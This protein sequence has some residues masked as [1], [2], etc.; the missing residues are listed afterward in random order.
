MSDCWRIAH[1]AS[2][3]NDVK[4]GSVIFAVTIAQVRFGVRFRWP[5]WHSGPFDTSNESVL[6]AITPPTRRSP[7]WVRPNAF[8]NAIFTVLPDSLLLPP[9]PLITI[10]AA[11]ASRTRKTDAMRRIT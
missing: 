4:P 7:P 10:T 8:E 9:A 11:H 2:L 5:S 1:V 6:P 3:R